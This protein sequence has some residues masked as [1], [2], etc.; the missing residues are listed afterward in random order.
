M[1]LPKYILEALRLALL[2]CEECQAL[3]YCADGY[4]Y[5]LKPA[6]AGVPPGRW[7]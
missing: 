4:E 5:V 2:R 1:K 3:T 6:K 7:K